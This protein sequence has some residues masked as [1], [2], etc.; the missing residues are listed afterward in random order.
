[1]PFFKLFY[2]FTDKS[3][4]IVRMKHVL[5]IYFLGG[6]HLDCKPKL[7]QTFMWICVIIFLR[8]N[9]GIEWLNWMLSV[10]LRNSDDIYLW[11]LKLFYFL[12]DNTILKLRYLVE[13][14]VE[15]AVT[16]LTERELMEST[17]ELLNELKKKDILPQKNIHIK[18]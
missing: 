8:K 18:T 10:C 9:L 15:S 6:W 3:Y 2:C 7:L 16:R 13:R 1:M 5:F 17:S 12:T 11:D 4:S 14:E